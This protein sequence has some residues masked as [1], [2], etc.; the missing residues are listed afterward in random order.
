MNGYGKELILDL[1]DYDSLTYA[2]REDIESFFET[3]YGK[4]GMTKGVN[5]T[6][7]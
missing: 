5:R 1:H 6:V 7:Y 3:F 2:K 4:A